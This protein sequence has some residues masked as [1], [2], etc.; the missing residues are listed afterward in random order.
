MTQDEIRKAIP[1][2]KRIMTTTHRTGDAPK[3]WS[4]AERLLA[5]AIMQMAEELLSREWEMG[6]MND[7]GTTNYCSDCLNEKHLGHKPD[8]I[9]VALNETLSDAGKV[10]NGD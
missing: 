4:F 9:Y 2:A 7:G 3:K 10:T 8:C 1:L 5:K 6:L